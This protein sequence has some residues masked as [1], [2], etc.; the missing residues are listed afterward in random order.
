MTLPALCITPAHAPL[1]D[2]LYLHTAEVAGLPMDF[3]YAETHGEF[4]AVYG[5]ESHG[6]VIAAPLDDALRV[7][8]NGCDSLLA[9][10]ARLAFPHATGQR[11]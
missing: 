6:E 7:G 2:A 8:R 5:E 10:A 4:V 11:A 3:Y 9:R 1:D